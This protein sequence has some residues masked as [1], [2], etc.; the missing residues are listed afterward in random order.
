[1]NEEMD[2]LYDDEIESKP[3]DWAGMIAKLLKYWKYI[4]LVTVIFGALGVIVALS[5]HKT[6]VVSMTLAPEI[7]SKMSTS[8]SRLKSIASMFGL[9]SATTGSGTDAVNFMIF[10][11][12]C[13]STP[14]LTGLFDV[15]VT[16]TLTKKDIKA[17]KKEK[18]TTLYKFITKEDEPQKGLKVWIGGV[19]RSLFG[20]D[21]DE[22]DENKDKPLDISHLTKA[23]D[24]VVKYLSKSISTDVDK[25][26]GITTIK[27]ALEDPVVVTAIA[28]T[29]CRRLQDYVMEYRTK[30]A[31]QDLDYYTTLADE[32]HEKLVDAQAAYAQSVDFDHSVILQSVKS[33][34]QRLLAEANLAQQVYEQ[35][36][37]QRVF[38]K[39]KVQELKPA[40]A[41]IQPATMP[42]R[43]S[44]TSR[45]MIVLVF[46]F[47]GF[48]AASVW[49]LF[50]KDF[51]SNLKAQV[52]EKKREMT[53]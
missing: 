30:K 45:K 33:E 49:K 20:T 39:A 34:T 25:K 40:F 5:K 38:A 11:E 9:G 24:G 4:L 50:L 13:G 36:E 27:V 52:K 44:G 1:M 41:V 42:L 51:L 2:Y 26:T 10:P 29:I 17:G 32:A 21:E 53:E 6:Y 19:M 16:P 43:P 28:D 14:F 3:I 15:P 18:T 37:Q 22:E 12:V 7:D 47:V 35:M 23:Q 48:V 8:T 31:Q 46:M